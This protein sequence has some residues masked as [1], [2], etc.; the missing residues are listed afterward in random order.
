MG[1]QCG[2]K[3]FR[4]VYGLKQ[5]NPIALRHRSDSGSASFL[6]QLWADIQECAAN[7]WVVEALTCP[8]SSYLEK[9]A[10]AAPLTDL[11]PLV[12]PAS[13]AGE[14]TGAM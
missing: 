5:I 14:E 11:A 13:P 12:V 9:L 3:C 1:G 6:G 4:R 8:Q 7:A 10:A 2:G